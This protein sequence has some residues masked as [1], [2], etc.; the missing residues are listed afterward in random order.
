MPMEAGASFELV[1]RNDELTTPPGQ[2]PAG[3]ETEHRMTSRILQADP[4]RRL[5]FTWGESGEV[6]FDLRQDGEHVR[7][8]ITH[9]RPPSRDVLLKVAAGWHGHVDIMAARLRGEA[10]APFWDRW[11]QLRDEYAARLPA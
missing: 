6:S 2:R 4:P 7:L 8:T 10:P 5:A 9:C 11:L 1:W 3:F